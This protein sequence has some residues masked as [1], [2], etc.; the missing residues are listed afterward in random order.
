MSEVINISEQYVIGTYARFNVVF[1]SGKGA[2]LIDDCGKDYIDFGSGI[3]VNSLGYA[4]EDWINAVCAQA[5]T[6]AHVSNLYYTEPMAQLA[7]KLSEASCGMFAKTFFANSGAEA[8]EGAVKLARKY[9]YDKY[10]IGRSDIVTLY[11]SFHGRTITTLAATGQDVFHDYFFPF[12]EGFKYAKPNNFE[13]VKLQSKNACAIMLESIQGEGGVNLLD[14]S[15]VDQVASFAEENDILLIFDEVQTGI[16][17]TGKLFGFEHFSIK[18]DIITIA[19][20]L[21][22]GLPIGAVLCSE[23]LKNVLGKGHHAST[24]GGNPIC[25]RGALVVLDKLTCPG[26][27]E[28]VAKTGDYIMNRIKS[29]GSS[30]VGDVRGRGFM[31]GISII[32]AENR[33]IAEELLQN[34]VIC[35][36]AGNNTLRL[37]PPLTIT[38]AEVDEGLSC[39]QK[40]LK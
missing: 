28:N 38:K 22:G 30:L 29:M 35:L 6:L 20:G 18:P 24:F 13:S 23:K 19:K 4:D 7:K 8:N 12:T 37:L 16:G 25:S 5:K 10:G 26:F 9:S 32:G 17:R 33:T 39:M 15:F 3:G 40:V 36:T 21:G 14:K 31:I 34:G 1:K 27:L 11:G 2:T